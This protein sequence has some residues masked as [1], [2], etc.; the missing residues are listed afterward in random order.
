[1]PRLQL[2]T[3]AR[4]LERSLVWPPHAAA[5][6]PVSALLY[7]VPP[8]PPT[9]FIPPIHS[10]AHHLNPSAAAPP[11]THTPPPPTHTSPLQAGEFILWEGAPLD[12]SAKFYIIESGQVDCFRTFEVG[13]RLREGRAVRPAKA[14]GCW[15]HACFIVGRSDR[16]TTSRWTVSRPQGMGQPQPSSSALAGVG[17]QQGPHAGVAGALMPA[18]LGVRT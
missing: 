3:C 13:S 9:H 16:W 2:L 12:D 14:S 8:S 6:K 15:H 1:M 11:P 10:P 5:I 7:F 17:R 18:V 4:E